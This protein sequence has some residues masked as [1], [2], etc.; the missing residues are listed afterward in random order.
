MSYFVKVIRA[1][2]RKPD[3]LMDALRMYLGGIFMLKGVL[4]MSNQGYLLE[5][6]EGGPLSS[7]AGAAILSHYV[8]L[9]H[10]VGG[11]FLLIGLLTRLSALAQLPALL[12]AIF[13]VHL[14]N[15][16]V[17]GE[18]Q[19]LEYAL[20]VFVLTV[21]YAL[22]GAGRISVDA[23]LFEEKT[24]DLKAGDHVEIV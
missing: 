6:I 1:I 15:I 23:K 16:K 9:A 17:L 22:F 2:H 20:L 4:F 13:F 24:E 19:S 14:P 3:Y 5:M 18:F 21:M 10:L 11:F 12:G 7:F 8:I